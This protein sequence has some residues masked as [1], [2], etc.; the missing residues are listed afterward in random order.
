LDYYEDFEEHLEITL[1]E[2]TTIPV[3]NQVDSRNLIYFVDLIPHGALQFSPQI[4]DLV[5]TSNNL[6]TIL[7]EKEDITITCSSRSNL[8]EELTNFRRTLLELA[9][10]FDW[11]IEQEKA[12]SGWAPNPKSD[13]LK[14]IKENFVKI[15][16]NE[17][18]VEAIHAG[19]ECGVLG[20]KIAKLQIV[21]IGPDVK[22]P[23]TPD[24]R[25]LIESVHTMYE[26]LKEIVG[27]TSSL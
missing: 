19:L 18:K 24:E 14:Y 22:N 13:L 26:I 9:L 7:I 15:L 11:Q 12:Y 2:I 16:G 17:P 25:V 6:A 8:D 23:H 27:N 3:F 20:V 21:S 5:E 4:T 10:T 1:G